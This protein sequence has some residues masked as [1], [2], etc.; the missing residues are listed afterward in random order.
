MLYYAHGTVLLTAKE[1]Q[2]KQVKSRATK[3]LS[4]IQRGKNLGA[5]STAA[6]AA[7]DQTTAWSPIG[8]GRPLTAR[9]APSWTPGSDDC[10]HGDRLIV[11]SRIG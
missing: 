8:L 7:T 2:A 6:P 9:I 5:T 11:D 10:G 4:N 1:A 3:L